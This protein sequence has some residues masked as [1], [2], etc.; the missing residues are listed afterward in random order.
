MAAVAYIRTHKE[1]GSFQTSF[2][3]GKCKVAPIK[4]ISVP[5]LELETAAL[6][7]RLNTSIQIEMT[8]KFEKVY[9]WTDSRVVLDW[10]S[11]TKKQNVFVS[12]RLEEINKATKT[13]EWNRVPSKF[14]PADHETRGLD[15]SEIYPKWLTAPQFLQ[16]TESSRKDMKKFSTV[17]GVNQE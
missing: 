16:D 8:Q 3:L 6:G 12:N 1:D 17:G 10:I 11:S 7:T 14:N 4:Q 5:K 2:S 15:S 9:L 13:N